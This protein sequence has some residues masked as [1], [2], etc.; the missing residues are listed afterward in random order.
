MI[1]ASNF[2]SCSGGIEPIFSLSFVRQVMNG[3]TLY[4]TNPVFKKRLEDQGYDQATIDRI[5]NIAC[6]EGTV[7]NAADLEPT[8]ET[9]RYVAVV[10]TEVPGLNPKHSVVVEVVA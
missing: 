7:Q 10:E 4:E 1:G 2:G 6:T 5:L 9:R 8:A 3:Q